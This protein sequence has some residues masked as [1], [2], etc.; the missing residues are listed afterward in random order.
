[1]EAKLIKTGGKEIL[2]IIY[3]LSVLILAV[4]Y[5]TVPERAIFLENQMEWWSEMFGV[6]MEGV[7]SK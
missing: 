4:I 2:F 6:L 3:I 1:M 7:H 5:F